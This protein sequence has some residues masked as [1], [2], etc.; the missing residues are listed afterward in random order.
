MLAFVLI[1]AG[2]LLLSVLYNKEIREEVKEDDEDSLNHCAMADYD[3][4]N[5]RCL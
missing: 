1:S 5:R 4:F 3:Y 2:S